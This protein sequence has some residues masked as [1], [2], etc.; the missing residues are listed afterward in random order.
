[1]SAVIICPRCEDSGCVIPA[2]E[3]LESIS[4]MYAA[5]QSCA[6]DP[7]ISKQLP[8]HQLDQP[9]RS[10][11]DAAM[12]CRDCGKR[13]LDIVIAHVLRILVREGLRGKD[14]S[15][16]DVGTP[17]RSGIRSRFLRD[18]AGTC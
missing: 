9:F 1:M 17:S 7:L 6:P 4:S 18:L 5:C 10:V 11:D 14:A 16:S 12:R 8:F 3:V 15:L 2:K 13:H